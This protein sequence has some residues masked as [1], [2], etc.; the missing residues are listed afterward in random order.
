MNTTTDRLHVMLLD[1]TSQ[2][3]TRACATVLDGEPSGTSVVM[4]GS[5]AVIGLV[6]LS[7]SDADAQLPTVHA[8]RGLLGMEPLKD[9]LIAAHMG[10][11]LNAMAAAHAAAQVD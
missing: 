7:P 2:P 3:A 4:L 6:L 10:D 9:Q 1:E 8:E 5:G 11:L